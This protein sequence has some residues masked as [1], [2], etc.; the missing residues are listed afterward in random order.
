MICI[1]QQIGKLAFQLNYKSLYRFSSETIEVPDSSISRN[2]TTIP[3]DKDHTGPIATFEFNYGPEGTYLSQSYFVC[4]SDWALSFLLE[5]LRARGILPAPISHSQDKA[6]SC[7]Y[8]ADLETTPSQAS[9]TP[10]SRA[11]GSKKQTF[12]S[13]FNFK[14]KHCT[15][16]EESYDED[17]PFRRLVVGKHIRN[18]V[19]YLL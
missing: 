1:I 6:K 9:K 16:S 12:D 14:G 2:H 8:M 11:S 15:V 3:Y 13:Y 4:V 5:S 18:C 7:D 17:E 19:L 10:T